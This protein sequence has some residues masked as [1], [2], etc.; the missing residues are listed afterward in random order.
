MKE[1]KDVKDFDK[2]VGGEVG[3]IVLE[4]ASEEVTRQGL[5]IV[6]PANIKLVF[7]AEGKLWYWQLDDENVRAGR[8]PGFAIEVSSTDPRVVLK[9]R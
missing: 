7:E 3:C 4:P 8:Y 6:N 9:G 1:F 2:W 5:R